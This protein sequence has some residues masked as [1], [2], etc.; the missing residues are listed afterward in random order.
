MLQPID[1]GNERKSFELLK[2]C[3]RWLVLKWLARM[4]PIKDTRYKSGAWDMG[5]VLFGIV[6][7]LVSTVW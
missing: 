6:Y 5:L 2:G 1:G 7:F 3:I 4:I